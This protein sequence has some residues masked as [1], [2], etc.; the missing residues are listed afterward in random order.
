MKKSRL[1]SAVVDTNLFVSGLILK[2]GSPYEIVEALR[3]G[4]FTLVI[5]EPI[6][7]EYTQV[8]SRPRFAEQY[9]LT[10][11]EVADF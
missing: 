3:R 2:R 10:Q 6:Y 5:S 9:A 1:L 4:D 11:E 7:T 8:L